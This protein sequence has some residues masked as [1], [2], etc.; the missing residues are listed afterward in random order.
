MI[1]PYERIFT[2][3]ELPQRSPE[4]L[5]WREGK[6]TATQ[7]CVIMDETPS[8]GAQSWEELRTWS[9]ED[10][11]DNEAMAR[12]RRLE[13]AAVEALRYEW[14]VDFESICIERGFQSGLVIGASLDAVTVDRNPTEFFEIKVPLRGKESSLW[15]GVSSGQVPRYY[16]WQI[17]HQFLALGKT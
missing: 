14:G 16:Y 12:G 8:W 3:E 7:A 2:E 15:T 11:K 17:V 13:P 10:V 4:W 1:E 6:V 5:R 9:E